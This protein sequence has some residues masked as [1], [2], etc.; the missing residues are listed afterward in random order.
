MPI[1]PKGPS[2]CDVLFVG[3][4]P[5]KDEAILG[6]PFV[7]AAGK[8]LDRQLLDAGFNPAECRF[9]NVFLERPADNDLANFCGKRA[10]VGKDYALP[11]LSQ[12]KYI[13]PEYLGDLDKLANEIRTTQPRLIVALGNTPCW[14]LVRRT[15]IKTLRGSVLP[16][17]LVKDG[18][19]VLPTFHPSYIMRGQWAD[20]VLVIG[21]LMKAK[22][23]L[24]VGFSTPRRELWIEPTIE[25]VREFCQRVLDNP[26]SVLSFD[27]ETFGGTITCIGFA[28]RTDLA[29]TIPFY[30]PTAPDR[31]YWENPD[32]ELEAWH[33]CY[34]LLTSDI[35]KL[36][37]N[38]L[39]DIQYLYRH[40]IQVRKYLHDTMIRHHALYPEMQKG[41]GFMATLYT[42]EAPWKIL[43]D[44]NK[45][46]FKIDDE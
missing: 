5:G 3:E 44:R 43:R 35:P 29:I 25:E 4:A 6:V 31:N 36:G 12:G 33:W 16:C 30:D 20:R 9:T 8:E 42:D 7:G 38:G 13:R 18:P 2:P 17:E 1:K 11:P 41:L 21:D 22:R 37:Q 23:Y 45:D 39:Y 27:I 46:N 10:D 40:R 26:P 15:G 14:A 19:P 32:H 28:P 34:K 24:D